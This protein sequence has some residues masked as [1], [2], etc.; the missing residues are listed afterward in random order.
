MAA[1]MAVG[2]TIHGITVHGI[3]RGT[4][5]GIGTVL[6]G[7]TATILGT[8]HGTTICIGV[9]HIMGLDIMEAT[10]DIGTTIIMTVRITA[11]SMAEPLLEV[12]GEVAV[13]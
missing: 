8:L 2:A 12:V 3:T 9:T 4:H 1:I 7:D 6:I 10:M 11:T 5:L 13:L